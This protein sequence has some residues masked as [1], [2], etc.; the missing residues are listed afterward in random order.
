MEDPKT[1]L[2]EP[3]RKIRRNAGLALGIAIGAGVGAGIGAATGDMG[4]WLAVGIGVGTATGFT[5]D[6]H[7]SK[8]NKP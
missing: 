6:K 3:G 2:A 7:F 4:V 1:P 8:K 5:L